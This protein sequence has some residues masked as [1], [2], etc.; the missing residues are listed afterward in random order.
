MCGVTLNRTIYPSVHWERC[1]DRH[2]RNMLAHEAD[3]LGQTWQSIFRNPKIRR[4]AWQE[5]I[6]PSHI[7]WKT[8]GFGKTLRGSHKCAM[9]PMSV[10]RP[11]GKVRPQAVSIRSTNFSTW[12]LCCMSHGPSVTHFTRMYRA[13]NQTATI[14]A[15][16]C[17]TRRPYLPIKEA[18]LEMTDTTRVA[19]APHLI[20]QS[21]KEV[22]LP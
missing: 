17:T 16:S 9:N 13:Y 2:H 4:I 1:K 15:C 7:M 21:H 10:F 6:M 12:S 19:A 5:S 18:G 22:S 8:S 11:T 3:Q 20:H 14:P